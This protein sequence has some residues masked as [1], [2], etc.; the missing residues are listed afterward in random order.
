[1]CHGLL[2]RCFEL[3]DF[4]TCPTILTLAQLSHTIVESLSH[5]SYVF[6]PNSLAELLVSLKFLIVG[7]FFFVELWKYATLLVTI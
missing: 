3:I 1:M 4:V 5:T 6:P 7:F 2:A